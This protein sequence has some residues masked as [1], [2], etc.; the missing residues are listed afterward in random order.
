MNFGFNSNVRVSGALYHV[1]TEDRGP[2]HPYLDTVVYEAGR[3]VYKKSSSYSDFAATAAKDKDLAEQLHER[4]A[5]Q[6]RDVIAQL[7]AGTLV[8]Q[9]QGKSRPKLFAAAAGD[10]LDV[11][12]ENSKTWFAGGNAS[13]EVTLREKKSEQAVVGAEIEALVE[14]GKDCIRCVVENSDAR[15]MATLKFPMPATILEGASLVIRASKENLH[16]ELR[17]LL[18][19][20]QPTPVPASVLK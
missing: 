2:S 9:G 14:Q 15:G 6:H 20:K 1:Q 4:L 12:L 5:Q 7:E 13:L 11:R 16:G 19:L 3:V 10:E 8:L 17:F 18:K